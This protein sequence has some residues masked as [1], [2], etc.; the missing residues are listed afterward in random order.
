ML[1]GRRFRG[2][3]VNIGKSV[4]NHEGN[5]CVL[6]SEAVHEAGHAV[7]ARYLGLRLTRIWI[8]CAENSGETV[9][10][11]AG[12]ADR[13]KELL[14]LVATRACMR[15][16]QIETLREHGG[17][18]DVV[19][20]HNLLEEMKPVEDEVSLSL[21]ISKLDA[22]AE[23]VFKRENILNAARALAET[24]SRVNEI[25]GVQAEAIID[26]NLDV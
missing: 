15:S 2:F 9:V 14:I 19:E 4:S 16:F 8:N 1:V 17:L 10:Q 21:C 23:A 3:T 5:N 25:T 24:L 7:M 18:G 11:W 6:A 13:P 22:E 26:R 12:V 20:L